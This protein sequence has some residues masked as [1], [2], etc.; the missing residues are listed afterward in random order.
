[1]EVKNENQNGSSLKTPPKKKRTN[2]VSVFDRTIHKSQE[3]IKEMHADLNWLT[4]NEVYGLLRSV[5][6]TLRDQLT[7][8]EAAHFAAQLPLLLRGA[9]Y[10]S[11]DPKTEPSRGKTREEF[12]TTV[13]DKMGSMGSLNFDLEEGVSVA[14]KVIDRH[15]SEGEMSDIKDSLTLSLKNLIET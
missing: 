13:K 4:A 1:M 2:R 5:L 6:Q 8:D 3:W 9:F 15:I 12:I 11:W 10:E 14:L 7:V